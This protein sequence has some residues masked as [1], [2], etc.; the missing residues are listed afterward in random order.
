MEGHAQWG[1]I[2]ILSLSVNPKVN[3]VDEQVIDG[4]DGRDQ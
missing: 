4:V 3:Q 2:V 1:H